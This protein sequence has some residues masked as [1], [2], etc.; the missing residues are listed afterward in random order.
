MKPSKSSAFPSPLQRGI[1][2]GVVTALSLPTAFAADRTWSSA[3]ASGSWSVAANWGGT[4]PVANDTLLFATSSTLALTNDL[5]PNIL[6]R[7]MTYQPG[8]SAFTMAGNA[9]NLNGDITNSSSNLQTIG[10]PIALRAT[11]VNVTGSAAVRITGKTTVG[12]LGGVAGAN[13][14]LINN[15]SAGSLTLGNVDL[16]IDPDSVT[17]ILTLEG[18]GNT[19]ISGVVANGT[20]SLTAN[21][22]LTYSGAASL[23]INGINGSTYTGAT[24]INSGTL[25]LDFSNMAVPTNLL[26]LSNLTLGANCILKAKAGAVN[27]Q[28]FNGLT[29]IANRSSSFVVNQNGATAVN[30]SLDGLTRGD[31]ATLNFV[32]PTS[33][34]VTTSTSFSANGVATNPFGT[35][36]QTVGGSTWLAKTGAGP[37][38][39]EALP[40]ASYSATYTAT[41]HVDV[42]NGDIASGV[43]VSTLRFSGAPNKFLYLDG[44]NTISTGG[45][46]VT[47][48][49][50]G[51]V[52]TGGALRGN[53]NG[54]NRELVVINN[55][56]LEISSTIANNGSS[57]SLTVAGTGITTLAG[58]NTFNGDVSINQGTTRI[59]TFQNGAISSAL[60]IGG[61]GAPA[62]TIAP[63]A[64]LDLNGFDQTVGILGSSAGTILNN[65]GFPCILTAKNNSI[66][67]GVIISGGDMDLVSDVGATNAYQIN[68]SLKT[69]AGRFVHRSGIV[70]ST[71]YQTDFGTSTIVL[72][73]ISAGAVGTNATVGVDN[74]FTLVSGSGSLPNNIDV[75]S[76]GFL[77][78]SGG[79]TLDGNITGGGVLNMAAGTATLTGDN[80]LFFGTFNLWRNGASIFI[81]STTASSALAKYTFSTEGTPSGTSTYAANLASG[82]IVEMGEL[83]TT[84]ATSNSR[85]RNNVNNTTATFRV[86]AL[87][88]DSSFGGTIADGTGTAQV[89]ALTKV[90]LGTLTL[91]GN[92][93]HSGPTQVNGGTL[94]IESPRSVSAAST[95]TVAVDGTL[96]G[97]G[98]FAGTVNA[99]GSIAPGQG[100]GT[101]TV[102][103][104]VLSG[105]LATEISAATADK[106]VSTGNLNLTGATLTVT[107]ITAGTLPSYIIAEGNSRTGTFAQTNLPP[108]YSV[109]Y[110]ATQVIVSR[111]AASGYDAW[112]SLPANGLSAGVNDGPNQDP[113]LDGIS[114]LLEFVL[115]GIPAGA[116]AAN[117]GVLPTLQLTPTALVFSFKR[118]DLS[119]GDVTLKV[120]WSSDL[121]TWG[122]AKEITITAVDAGIVDVTEDDPNPATDTIAVSI[123]RSEAV[124]GK[125]MARI[126]VSR[127]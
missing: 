83:S 98:T 9:V 72:D 11:I 90:G 14:T 82:G 67:N 25:N 115:S 116:G 35:V 80:S 41:D 122:A 39:L 107:E 99:V 2:Y 44:I 81:N 125:L 85:L 36:Y 15:L 21:N 118:A 31:R 86:G 69:F 89:T 48:A 94:V 13:R 100:I 20:S 8:A 50:T 93:T 16:S 112:K 92:S 37:Y 47:P 88:T 10:F 124:N 60:G 97:T 105:T 30:I 59:G 24:T 40:N 74:S 110:N 73:I 43:T 33:G 51:S 32:L 119:E 7:G 103:A 28:A 95:V 45:I 6:I 63:G 3:P 29:A 64:I 61:A 52:I 49:A 68:D 42:S 121:V 101:L 65:S 127:P 96:G 76:T 26:G 117:T 106:L 79:R 38:T 17:R 123:P 126:R 111:T 19:V 58:N 91:T 109:S 1:C 78:H 77:N 18:T 57:S 55:G 102:G 120:Q 5:A 71:T 75:A 114:N 22:R 4:A 27:S 104:T 70:R 46:L 66:Q 62:V 34:A 56:S 12:I 108:G 54:G 87:N 53:P 84:G 23:L 113:D